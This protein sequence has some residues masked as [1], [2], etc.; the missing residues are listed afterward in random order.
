M[1]VEVCSTYLYSTTEWSDECY[2]S[3]DRV[4]TRVMIVLHPN[5]QQSLARSGARSG[6]IFYFNG[7]DTAI[8]SCLN[9]RSASP[10]CRIT[11]V[12]RWWGTVLLHQR[13]GSDNKRHTTNEE[14]QTVMQ[15]RVGGGVPKSR[16]TIH[17]RM[18]TW[19]RYVR[20]GD[21]WRPPLTWW[22]LQLL[23]WS[24]RLERRT[25]SRSEYR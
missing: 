8:L 7:S 21:Q 1:W 24:R 19:R 10:S 18:G 25:P 11:F 15:V 2:E 14:V 22:A 5:S 9:S 3:P 20:P 17:R 4:S 12:S 6:W 13:R 16:K 23:P